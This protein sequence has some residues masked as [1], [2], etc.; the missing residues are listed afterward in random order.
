MVRLEG[1][2]TSSDGRGLRSLRKMPKHLL[3]NS[4]NTVRD[5]ETLLIQA[6][7]TRHVGNAKNETFAAA[8]QW[9]QVLRV[10]REHYLGKVA[11]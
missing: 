1:V 8:A 7:G 4:T 2:L 10:E 9:E 11:K 3:T 5:I 6:M